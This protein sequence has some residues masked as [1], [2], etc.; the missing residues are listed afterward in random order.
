VETVGRGCFFLEALFPMRLDTAMPIV[1]VTNSDDTPLSFHAK[2]NK[3][4]ALNTFLEQGGH[5]GSK[6]KNKVSWAGPSDCGPGCV[7]SSECD[8]R[9]AEARRETVSSFQKDSLLPSAPQPPAQWGT[10]PTSDCSVHNGKR[11]KCGEVPGC[12][13]NDVTQACSGGGGHVQR[14]KDAIEKMEA[15]Y[16]Q[17]GEDVLEDEPAGLGFDMFEDGSTANLPKKKSNKSTAGPSA[18]PCESFSKLPNKCRNNG[19]AY[20]F[21]SRTC[22]T[23]KKKSMKK[24]MKKSAASKCPPGQRPVSW[25][26]GECRTPCGEGERRSKM[27]PFG[28]LPTTSSSASKPAANGSLP[29]HTPIPIP[30]AAYDPSVPVGAALAA[31]GTP[32]FYPTNALTAPKR[33]KPSPPKAYYDRRSRALSEGE[34]SFTMGGVTYRRKS[35]ESKLFR[36]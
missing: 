10:E 31:D 32:L 36:Q 4:S 15:F 33:R 19:C 18:R 5:G 22:R 34:L 7:L 11:F 21:E 6:G 29:V 26:G 1:S 17:F 16:S 28:C 9:V 27:Y 12:Y 2:S 30:V 8:R 14:T 13:Y 25:M 3:A 23:S 24:S 20:D 35:K